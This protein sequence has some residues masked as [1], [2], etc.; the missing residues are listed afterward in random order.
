MLVGALQGGFLFPLANIT[1][2]VCL[3]IFSLS[4]PTP[5]CPS[6]CCCS[7]VPSWSISAGALWDVQDVP[8]VPG[9]AY[10]LASIKMQISFLCMNPSR[11]GQWEAGFFFFFLALTILCCVFSGKAINS[12]LFLGC[13]SGSWGEAFP[14]DCLLYGRRAACLGGEIQPLCSLTVLVLPEC[15][16][17]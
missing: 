4:L 5:S 3:S 7:L 9:T 10:S 17:C 15:W 16:L 6:C 2:A 8:L 13:N 14:F 11:G 1:H 12:I